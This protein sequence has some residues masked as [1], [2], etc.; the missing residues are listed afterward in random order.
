MQDGRVLECVVNVSEGRSPEVL[1][2]IA[3]AAGDD[4]LDVHRDPDHHRAVLTLI[5]PDAPRAV[6]AE[7]VRRLDL[8]T[9]DGVHP[10]LGVVDVVPFVPLARSAIDDAIA[11]RDAFAAW[12]AA[13]LGV[14]CFLYGPPGPEHPSLPELRR[15][16]WRTRSPD[17][18]SGSSGSP[19][20]ALD[21]PDPAPHPRILGGRLVMAQAGS[22]AIICA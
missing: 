14:P 3:A 1:E 22:Y 15:Q 13:D 19:G 4:L 5:G 20:R 12:A 9:H 18:G 16:A 17:V 10:R 8:R 2:A 11:A 7:A 6:A 21:R